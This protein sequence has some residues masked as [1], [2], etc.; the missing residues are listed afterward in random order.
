MAD[1][2][3]CYTAELAILRADAEAALGIDKETKPAPDK[4]WPDQKE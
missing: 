1:N 2:K 3:H 4:T